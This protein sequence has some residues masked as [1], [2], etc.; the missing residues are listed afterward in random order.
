MSAPPPATTAGSVLVL[1]S[2]LVCPPLVHYLS[3][4][5][6]RLTLASRTLR[7]ARDIVDSLPSASRAY[8]T[9]VAYD[10]DSE[11]VTELP[12]LH[13]LVS[14]HDLT[15]SLLPYIHH[16]KAAKVCLQHSKHFFTTS[17]VSKD[18]EALHE[19]VKAKGL[20]FMNEAGLDPG[21]AHSKHTRTHIETQR[22]HRHTCTVIS[23]H[24][25]TA[26][27][28]EVGESGGRL[29]EGTQ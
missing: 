2:G 7:K 19:Q 23:M 13:Q 22:T 12:Q 8:V 14:Q 24:G 25:W 21:H 1:G 20:C 29:S 16:V 3:S 18:M 26:E 11:P 10:I 9:A 27:C 4:F 5:G 17:Y 15:V 28:G 6:F